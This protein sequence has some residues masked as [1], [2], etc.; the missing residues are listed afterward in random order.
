[1][2]PVALHVHPPAMTITL[3]SDGTARPSLVWR[4]AS[5]LREHYCMVCRWGEDTKTG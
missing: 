1:M 4:A 3:S 2:N 5:A